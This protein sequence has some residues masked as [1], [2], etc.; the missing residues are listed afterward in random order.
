[1]EIL[2]RSLKKAFIDK[3]VPG[4]AY[5]PEVIINQP[6]N[7][8]FL[9]NTLQNELDN[10]QDFFFS[11]AFI[12]KDGLASIKAQLAD[13]HTKGY[14]GRLLTSTYLSF[15]QPKVFEDLLNI[16]NLEVKISTKPGFHAKGYLFS[17]PTH[18]SLIVGSSNLTL[19]AL[20]L[21][22]EWNVKL[23]SYEHG[24]IIHQV[25]RHMEKEWA[26]ACFLSTDWIRNYSK[27]Y[28]PPV[29]KPTGSSIDIAEEQPGYILPNTMQRQALDNLEQLR[30]DGHEK[31]LIISATGTGKTYLA[32]FDVLKYK[33][34]KMLFIVHREQI[35]NKAKE[36]F[37]QII[38]GP[39]SDFGI[40]SGNAREIE[41][42]YLFATIQTMSK[43]ENLQLFAEDYFD[44]IL[45]DEVHKAGA[46][47][48]LRT[49][50]YFKPKFLLG[51]TATPERTDALTFLNYS[52]TTSRMKSDYKMH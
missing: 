26:E 12:T 47:S 16:P 52:I 7:K 51:M 27:Y 37:Q 32:A 19:S 28:Q 34:K 35:L 23:T 4:S 22:Y 21:N 10:C 48:Y 11:I 43:S 15:N 18:H 17:Q 40:F 30:A 1:M 25:K 46:D 14:R 49:L 20:K 39:D 9:L 5:D 36:S 24:E 3:T 44:Y 31:G 13:L 45:I 8:T 41:A 29:F 33:P 42:T 6:N 2:E 38:G 50:H